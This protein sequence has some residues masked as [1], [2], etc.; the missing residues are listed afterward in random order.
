MFLPLIKKLGAIL[1]PQVINKKAFDS[2]EFLREVFRDL[3]CLAEQ[4]HTHA[5]MAPYPN[6]AQRL[7]QIAMEKRETVNTMKEKISGLLV[8]ID[9]SQLNL[10]SGKNHWERMVRDLEDQKTLEN[11]LVIRA[12]S[13]A[14][15]APELS[16]LLKGIK[17]GQLSHKDTLL[18]LVVRAD[19]QADQN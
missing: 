10:R 6:I 17:A 7:R 12:A 3:S 13:L 5:E 1:K 8:P 4:I 16:D 19:P 14:D 9:E 2:R 18:D 15:E 11:K